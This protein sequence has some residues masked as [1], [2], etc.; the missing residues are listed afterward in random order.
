MLA[1]GGQLYGDQCA[2]CHGPLGQGAPGAYPA[3]AG[4][5]IVTLP[6]PGNLVQAITSGGFPPGTAGNPRPYGMPG[7]DLPHDDLA[8]LATWLRASWGHDAAPVTAVQVL[9]A[10]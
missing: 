3:L 7:F 9:L 2:T 10:R 8:A 5:P 4:N 1:R 6:D